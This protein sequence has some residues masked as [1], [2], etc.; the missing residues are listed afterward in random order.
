MCVYVGF[1]GG[2]EKASFLRSK[3]VVLGRFCVSLLQQ[4]NAASVLAELLL[5]LCL[6]AFVMAQFVSI[7]VIRV[8]HQ[9]LKFNQIGRIQLFLSKK[10]SQTV[11]R[12]RRSAVHKLIRYGHNRP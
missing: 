8:T 7:D 1:R 5:G 10:L 6:N 3:V 2:A 12:K 9:S 11:H 4:T